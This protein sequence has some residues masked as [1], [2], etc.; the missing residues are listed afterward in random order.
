MHN[1]ELLNLYF[2]SR[3]YYNRMLKSKS[4]RCAGHVESMGRK[5]I[6]QSFG[7]KTKT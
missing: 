4:K 5:R 1:E 7:K 2:L 6:A 3:Y